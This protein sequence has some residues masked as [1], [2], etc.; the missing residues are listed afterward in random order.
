MKGQGQKKRHRLSKASANNNHE[1]MNLI[2]AYD[3]IS[4]KGVSILGL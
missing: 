4:S 1:E 3:G 2:G